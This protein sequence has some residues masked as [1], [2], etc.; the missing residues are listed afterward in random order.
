MFVLSFRESAKRFHRQRLRSVGQSVDL[1][2]RHHQAGDRRHR[3]RSQQE[4]SWRRRRWEITNLVRVYCF[5]NCLIVVW[6]ILVWV[7]I[8]ET[9]WLLFEKSG[10]SLHFRNCLIVVWKVLFEFVFQKLFDCCL[11]N[12]VW[13]WKI[14]F[15]F[16]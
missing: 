8:L 11:K 9:V 6:K 14:W 12:L 4:S 5:R 10:L 2:R 13:V 15:E 1:P 16:I 7:C 3:Q